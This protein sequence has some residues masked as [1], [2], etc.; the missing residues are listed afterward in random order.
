MTRYYTPHIIHC[1]IASNPIFWL[2]ANELSVKVYLDLTQN[3]HVDFLLYHT[4]A[5]LPQI[6][7]LTLTS[8]LQVDGQHLFTERVDHVAT[9]FMIHGC[10]FSFEFAYSLDTLATHMFSSH[11]YILIFYRSTTISHFKRR[12]SLKVLLS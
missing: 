10:F 11:E 12:T 7:S 3:C 4:L 9:L 1:E 5:A 8:Y 2:S 6:S